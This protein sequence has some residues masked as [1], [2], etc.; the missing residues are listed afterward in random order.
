MKRKFVIVLLLFVAL[1]GNGQEKGYFALYADHDLCTSGEILLLKAFAPSS[2][3]TGVV[4]IDLVSSTG[5]TITKINLEI[6]D[7]QANGYIYL[8]DSLSSGYYFLRTSTRSASLHTIKELFIAN[9]FTGVPEQNEV[10]K[11]AGGLPVAEIQVREIVVDGL[12]K[13]FNR[14]RRGTASICLPD[15]LLKQI[16]GNIH[17]SITKVAQE[18]KSSPFVVDS[19][20]PP[21][22]VIEKEGII[23]DGIVTDVKTAK[24][25][26]DAVVYLSIPD[27]V[28]GFKYYNTDADG[29]F[30]F[31]LKESYG[32]VPVVIQ[33][34]DKVSAR[35]LKISLPDFESLRSGLPRFEK[36]SLPDE[37]LKALVKN[38]EAL[39][40]RKI[41]NQQEISIQ[42]ATPLK[43]DL[44]PFY[45]IPTTIVY[46][47]LF[48]DLPDFTEISRELLPGVKFRTYNRQPTLQVVNSA[49]HTFFNTTPLVLLNGIPVSDLNLIKDLGS[50]K[51]DRI[52]ICTGERFFG[53][54]IFQG[55]VAIYTIKANDTP[56]PDS[57]DLIKINLE[58][59]QPQ[60]ILNLPDKTLSTE[61]DLR[62]K[63][64]W[65]PSVKPG[66]RIAVDFQT[67]DIKGNF[68][69][70]IRG[71]TANGMLFFQEQIFEVN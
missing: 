29:R 57:D 19:K 61:P 1:A 35:L 66:K 26:K 20:F 52:E 48:T 38:N 40:I 13:S 47:N 62:Q 37:L 33:C 42:P 10:L 53:D 32:K 44:Y 3:Q 41:F 63:L 39:T 14:R 7:H 71:K 4:T 31:Q 51:I 50:K 25:V 54:L 55:V 8:P 49:S 68:K 15:D 43:P 6:I 30:Y 64:L 59:I 46:P 9:R 36:K 24:P 12:E 65:K 16:D 69:L 18:Y 67:S 27:S 11:P 21:G 58:G 5:K 28:P 60:A 23:L 56:L 22:P 45:G 17:I 2:E 70:I 34:V